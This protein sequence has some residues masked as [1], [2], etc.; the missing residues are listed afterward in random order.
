MQLHREV[1]KKGCVKALEL[2]H[3]EMCVCVSRHMCTCTKEEAKGE[4]AVGKEVSAPEHG[5][6]VLVETE[7]KEICQNLILEA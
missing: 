6:L 2:N 7:P 3:R 1:R 4:E 5:S